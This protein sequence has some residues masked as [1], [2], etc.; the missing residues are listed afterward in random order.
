MQYNSMKII[1]YNSP[2][3]Q[4]HCKQDNSKIGIKKG[5]IDIKIVGNKQKYRE[6]DRSGDPEPIKIPE[7]MPLVFSKHD[8]A[9]ILEVFWN[10]NKCFHLLRS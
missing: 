8:R 7:F 6:E 10:S 3:Q 5:I 4:T 2:L 1:L 9:G